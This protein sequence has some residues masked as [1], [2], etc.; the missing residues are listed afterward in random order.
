MIDPSLFLIANAV[1]FI[2][3]GMVGYMIGS[4]ARATREKGEGKRG[5]GEGGRRKDEGEQT[6]AE[7]GV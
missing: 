6:R 1:A 7:A 4:E 3:G 2:L 5:K